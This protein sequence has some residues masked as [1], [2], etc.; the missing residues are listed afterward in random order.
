MFLEPWASRAPRLNARIPVV[1][2]DPLS[3]L[4]QEHLRGSNGSLAVPYKI[5]RSRDPGDFRAY[6]DLVM[7]VTWNIY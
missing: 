5:A 2:V 6:Q 7:W 3:D 1:D 4:E